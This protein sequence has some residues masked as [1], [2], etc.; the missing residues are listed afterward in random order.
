MMNEIQKQYLEIKRKFSEEMKPVQEKYADSLKVLQDSCPH[1]NKTVEFDYDYSYGSKVE[2][3][4][5]D[6]RWGFTCYSEDEP[7]KYQELM[8]GMK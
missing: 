5:P 3:D 8:E 4:C 2:V 7:A 6:C 1:T